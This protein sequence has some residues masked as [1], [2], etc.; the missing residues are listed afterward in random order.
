[1]WAV[2]CR[3]SS[4]PDWDDNVVPGLNIVPEGAGKLILMLPRPN[5]ELLLIARGDLDRNRR[6]EATNQTFRTAQS[7][8]FHSFHVDFHERHVAVKVEVIQLYAVDS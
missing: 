4:S 3:H 1:M 8:Q 6:P 2:P 7:I 5:P